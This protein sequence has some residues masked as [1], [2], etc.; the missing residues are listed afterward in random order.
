MQM[1]NRLII[2]SVVL[3][4]SFTGSMS[5]AAIGSSQVKHQQLLSISKFILKSP[6]H[7]SGSDVKRLKSKLRAE[8]NDEADI[9]SSVSGVDAIK[10]DVRRSVFAEYD[11][12]AGKTPILP[13][14]QN[15]GNH[16]QKSCHRDLPCLEVGL[17]SEGVAIQ[18]EPQMLELIDL[19]QNIRVVFDAAIKRD[20]VKLFTR[21]ET[22]LHW[23]EDLGILTGLAPAVTEIFLVYKSDLKIIPVSILAQQAD[24]QAQG[25]TETT[26]AAVSLTPAWRHLVSKT[27]KALEKALAEQRR[28]QLASRQ[29]SKARAL[30]V[31][32]VDERSKFDDDKIYPLKD[33]NVSIIGRSSVSE[34][35]DARG[36]LAFDRVAPDSRFFI[37]VDDP[38]GRVPSHSYEIQTSELAE[39]EA[40]RRKTLS[41]KSWFLYSKVFQ[42]SQD[43]SLSSFCLEAKTSD[44]YSGVSGLKASVSAEAMGPFYF[45]ELGPDPEAFETDASGRFC[46]FNVSPG[47]I[48]VNLFDGEQLV[49]ASAIPVLAGMHT[50]DTLFLGNGPG[51]ELHLAALPSATKQLYDDFASSFAYEPIDFIE[52][53]TIGLNEVLP[54]D[55]A[56]TLFVEAGLDFFRGR[57]YGLSRAAEFEPVL[58]S[59]ETSWVNLAGVSQLVPLFPRGFIEDLFHELHLIDGNPSVAFDQTLGSVL[60]YHGLK[61]DFNGGQDLRAR[62]FDENGI[63]QGDAWIFGNGQDGYVKSVFFNLKPGMYTVI[64]EDKS[65][66]MIDAS[67]TAV[68]Y[69]LVSLVQTGGLIVRKQD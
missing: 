45:N 55:R 17:D 21:D 57:I 47:L 13:E 46:F 31:Q 22:K 63:E 60:V 59:L 43:A 42:F 49:A 62:L 27:D 12:I 34:V 8:A 24:S 16:S 23:D 35:S 6:I 30:I 48:E 58:Y 4:F 65:G 41:Y 67:T 11:E 36:M 69:Q 26:R 56:S 9:F 52:F 28:Y 3:A 29:E 40:I 18:T 37:R 7:T 33:L 25:L 61:D 68:D 38:L 54:Q 32:L 20:E 53:L 51:F 14:K 50:D 15:A 5:Y 19:N 39:G 1:T 66:V 44:G 2:V 10:K 64:I